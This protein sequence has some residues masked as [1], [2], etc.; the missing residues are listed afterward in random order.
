MRNL[1][2]LHAAHAMTPTV[3][4]MVK[5]LESEVPITG[6]G[7]RKLEIVRCMVADSFQPAQA[8]GILDNDGRPIPRNLDNSPRFEEV[9]PVLNGVIDRFVAMVNATG[10]F[11]KPKQ[12]APAA[13]NPG[14]SRGD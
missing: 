14:G 5:R 3:I 11:P 4:D 9:W 6:Q 1:A 8:D 12:P 2:I 13:P 10:Q 7:A